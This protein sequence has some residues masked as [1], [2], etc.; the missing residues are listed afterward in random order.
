MSAWIALDDVDYENGCMSMVPGLHL[1]GDAIDFLNTVPDYGSLPGSYQGH[2][3][4]AVPC[5]V[6][7]GEVHFHRA[8]NWHG[9]HANASG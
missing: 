5:P 6:K 4:E 3:V 1:W 9:S 8:L 2:R 7:K